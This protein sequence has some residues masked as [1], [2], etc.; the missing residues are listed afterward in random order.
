MNNIAQSIA[1]RKYYIKG[2]LELSEEDSILKYINNLEQLKEEIAEEYMNYLETIQTERARGHE[3]RKSWNKAAK[4]KACRITDSGRVKFK[5]ADSTAKK[6]VNDA[7]R[8]MGVTR[9][10]KVKLIYAIDG[11]SPEME[12]ADKLT[13]ALAGTSVIPVEIPPSMKLQGFFEYGNRKIFINRNSKYPITYVALHE[14]IHRMGETHP[15]HYNRLE[16]IALNNIKEDNTEMI[17]RYMEKGYS[18]DEIPEE[19]VADLTAELL[20]DWGF[21]SKLRERETDLTKPLLN[22]LEGTLIKQ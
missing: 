15:E 14:T 2:K 20:H 11:W 22:I 16:T 18:A 7:N 19:F 10:D 3:Y 8:S 5:Y 17:K 13:N 1:R 9:K 6:A 12:M 21:V 4:T